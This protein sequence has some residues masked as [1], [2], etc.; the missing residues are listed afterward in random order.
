LKTFRAAQRVG[1]ELSGP[2]HSPGPPPVHPSQ[3]GRGPPRPG[4]LGTPV[5]PPPCANSKI[6]RNATWGKTWPRNE[7]TKT[8]LGP[9]SCPPPPVR[10]GWGVCSPPS[11]PGAFFFPYGNVRADAPSLPTMTEP[12]PLRSAYPWSSIPG[13]HPV[14][15]HLEASESVPPRSPS[16]S[17]PPRECFFR[18]PPIPRPPPEVRRWCFFDPKPNIGP[19]SG[20]GVG[21]ILASP[22]G[23]IPS[24]DPSS[25]LA[26]PLSLRGGKKKTAQISGR[27]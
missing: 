9:S 16:N 4:L 26:A 14:P 11:C 12:Y 21:G 22:E 2:C 1:T 24:R 15:F 25:R 27:L 13:P 18:S 3:L 8:R 17:V 5:C 7:S 20:L 6:A 23:C 10:H 19:E